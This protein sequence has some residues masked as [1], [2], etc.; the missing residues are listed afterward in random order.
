MFNTIMTAMLA[1]ISFGIASS[2]HCFGMCGGL[3]TMLQK[4]DADRQSELI[5]TSLY[6]IFRCFSYTALGM[7]AGLLGGQFT[8]FFKDGK[9]LQAWI[10]YTLVA[11]MIIMAGFLT[12]SQQH[13]PS[14]SLLRNINRKI[15]SFPLHRRA[16]I[17]GLLNPLLPCGVVL[18]GIVM[19]ASTG[20]IWGGMSF[21]GAF[22]LITSPSLFL[23]G[24]IFQSIKA[25]LSAKQYWWLQLLFLG[26]TAII[27]LYRTQLLLQN[28]ACH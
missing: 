10:A 13:L 6:L 28:Q 22:A 27:L 4:K 11:S 18:G 20:D 3:L 12:L 16:M 2:L 1:G 26:M 8:S 24:L 14:G 23:A 21:F 15:V 7:I 9:N 25:K 5:N 17:L 19:S